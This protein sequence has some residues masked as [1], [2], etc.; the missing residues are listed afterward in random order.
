MAH[1]GEVTLP[2]DVDD[3]IAHRPMLERMLAGEYWS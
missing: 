2:Q 3:M 1:F